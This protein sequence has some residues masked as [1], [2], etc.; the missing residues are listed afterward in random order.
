MISQVIVLLLTLTFAFAKQQ[1][2]C[3]HGKNKSEDNFVVLVLILGTIYLLNAH[4]VGQNVQEQEEEEGS[5]D[6]DES[7]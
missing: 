2:D 3:K 1:E 4:K 6:E 7:D 5:S